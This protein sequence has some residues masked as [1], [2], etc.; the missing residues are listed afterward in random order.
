MARIVGGNPNGEFRGKL[1]GW[2]FSR[3]KS[4]Q[5]ARAY[6]MPIDPS[7]V[8]QIQA[9]ARFGQAVSAFHSLSPSD[10]AAWNSFAA[11]YFSSKSRGN[12]P[13]VHSGVNAFVSLRNVLL[14]VSANVAP[15]AGL[16]ITVNSVPATAV[17]QET[18]VLPSFAPSAPM[19]GVLD[20]GAYS[21]GVI[22][23][24]MTAGRIVIDMAIIPNGSGPGPGPTPPAP[25]ISSILTDG[26]G[27]KVGFAVYASS[28]L[29]QAGT[30][31]QNPD[32]VLL[33]TTGVI[34]DY[35]TASV[36]T[37][38]LQIEFD[39]T[40]T[41]SKF[42]TDFSSNLPAEVSVWMFNNEGQMIRLSS[43]VAT[44]S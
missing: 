7:T 34:D 37:N 14:N 20:S 32:I 27:R 10:K 25:S 35:T 3:N 13:G 22:D 6:A 40:A 11:S 29:V 24:N 15:L 41:Q 18:I 2:V 36:V 30:F 9:R 33:G 23:A 5:I 28:P 31:V 39:L 12:V 38:S 16:D 17:S 8:A 19:Q 26:D 43:N 44:L 4:G 1:G 21:F 42:K